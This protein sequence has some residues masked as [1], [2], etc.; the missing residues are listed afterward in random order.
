MIVISGA[1]VLVAAVL[2]VL[3]IVS[4]IT[5][6]YAAIGLSI[7]SAVFLL[8]GVF[9][10]P[11]PATEP[12]ESESESTSR[13]AAAATGE[14]TVLAKQETKQP[15]KS[16]PAS[17]PVAQPA[18]QQEQEYSPDEAADYPLEAS[19]ADFELRAT[20][21]GADVLVISG[22]PRYHVG[23]C[24]YVEG[25]DD[26]EPLDI[27]EARELGFTP[28]GVC[29]PNETLASSAA[30]Q[31]AVAEPAPQPQPQPQPQ[32]AAAPTATAPAAN[33][34]NHHA[35]PQPAAQQPA[36]PQPVA[37]AP[38][39]AAPV[40]AAPVAPPAPAAPEAPPAPAPAPAAPAVSPV[41]AAE[42]VAQAAPAEPASAPAPL[43]AAAP[44]GRTRR[45]VQAVSA[46]KEYHRPD[47]ELLEGVQSD[48]L[49]KAA[50][51]RQAYL[52]CGVCKP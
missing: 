29:K 44:A 49:T 35:Q 32:P 7:V 40:A 1:L 31:T 12:R 2:L 30:A 39:A 38:V 11:V 19:N 28:C 51:V 15:A 14:P 52:A 5:L 33:S 37:A 42:P 9:Q 50:A 48:E 41:P 46:T 45:T 25:H 8:V 22:R 6:V 13:E 36:P 20:A 21:T 47:C 24:E 34:N 10:R 27:A 3:G 43:P 17:E 4:S 18:A 23:G 26:S 16:E